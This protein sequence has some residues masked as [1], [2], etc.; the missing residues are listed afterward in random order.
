MRAQ[1]GCYQRRQAEKP[2]V[3]FAHTQ[4]D[5]DRYLE[6]ANEFLGEPVGAARA[7]AVLR[8]RAMQH[9][10]SARQTAPP[11]IGGGPQYTCRSALKIPASA[12]GKS[13]I[14]ARSVLAESI[15]R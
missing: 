1:D 10:K 14:E 11:K 2:Q 5:L 9:P 15:L 7:Q 4:N 8:R 13:C 12:D 6:V 3:S